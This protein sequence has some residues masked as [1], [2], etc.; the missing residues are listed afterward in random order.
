MLSPSFLTKVND[1]ISQSLTNTAAGSKRPLQ[2]STE[3]VLSHSQAACCAQAKQSKLHHPFLTSTVS[4]ANDDRKLPEKAPSWGNLPTSKASASEIITPFSTGTPSLTTSQTP[5]NTPISNTEDALSIDSL[6]SNLRYGI[7]SIEKDRASLQTLSTHVDGISS[8]YFA[9]CLSSA[10]NLLANS[11]ENEMNAFNRQNQNCLLTPQ[12]S[13]FSSMC[14]TNPKTIAAFSSS[15]YSIAPG[16]SN[17][18]FSATGTIS[19]PLELNTKSV[20]FT[21]SKTQFESIK[22]KQEKEDNSFSVSNNIRQTRETDLGNSFN[23]SNN[24]QQTR[25]ANLDNSFSVSNNIRRTRETN[26]DNSFNLLSNIEQTRGTNLDSSFNL[27]NN[28][29]QTR[30]TNLGNSFSVSNN[31]RQTRETNLDNCFS[32]SNNIQQTRETNLDNSF[33]VLNNILQT[34]ET[35]LDSSFN[36]SNNIQQTR[37]TNLDNSFNALNNIQQTRETNLDNSFNVLNNIRQARETNL[38]NSFNVSNNIRQTRE[39][40]LDNSFNVWDN[41]Q[42]TKETNLDNSFNVLNNIRQ[43]REA[44]LEISLKDNSITSTSQCPLN[45][46]T[47]SISRH[48]E[49]LSQASSS[50]DSSGRINNSQQDTSCTRTSLTIEGDVT[51]IKDLPSHILEKLDI[52]TNDALEIGRKK[53]KDILEKGACGFLLGRQEIP[54]RG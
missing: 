7:S 22:I 52:F 38:V 27:S 20:N 8:K 50:G 26:L 9:S 21:Q 14:T 47:I 10:Q 39:T 29:Q 46:S 36:V 33:N 2:P 54:E 51:N 53:N 16:T 30:E 6:L 41:I 5:L 15:C 18:S 43:T 32:V 31:I 28:I 40:N 4:M 44:N 1:N 24:I 34:R 48:L 17:G 3:N 11:Q 25:E 49:H 45:S 13:N 35:N 19:S 42:Q 12:T 23:V 37:E